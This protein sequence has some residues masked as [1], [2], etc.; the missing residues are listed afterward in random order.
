MTQ[1]VDVLVAAATAAANA[2]NW[3]EA[4]RLWGEVHSAAPQ[5]PQAL[6]GLAVHA[7]QTGDYSTAEGHLLKAAAV[8]PHDLMVLHAI[9]VTRR[10]LG[11]SEGERAAI[12]AT[13]AVDPYFLPAM[14]AKANWFE[15]N[16]GAVSAAKM[17]RHCLRVAPPESHWPQTLSSQLAHGREVVRAHSQRFAMHLREK[18]ESLVDS[19]P[20]QQAQRWRESMSI[21]AGLSKPYHSDSN[22]LYAPRLPAVPFFEREQF[23]WVRALEAKTDEIRGELERALRE[24]SQS[25]VPYIGYK[26]G[27]PVNQ[28]AELNHSNRWSTLHLWSGGVP[29]QQNLALCPVTAQSLNQVEMADIGGLCPNAMFSALAPGTRIPPHHGETNARLVVH[30]PL[31]VP[32]G[33][34]YRVG[35]EWREWRVGEVLVFDD[36]LEHEA[37]NDGGEL[38]VVLI[39]D[40]WNPLL[41]PGEREVVRALAAAARTFA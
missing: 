28:W 14:L 1:S 37:R 31:I 40:V 26:P 29:N 17:Y 5:H 15:R 7:M 30:L 18:L 22:Q 24:A 21:M 4:G 33:C 41:A 19:L 25:F 8:V 11:D 35:F 32:A 36:T 39:F 16:G 10:H 9:G 12:E 3:A 6:F 38:R 2:G 13:L 23:G 34:S 27:E 20:S